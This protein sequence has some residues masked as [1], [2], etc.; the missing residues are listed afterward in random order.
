MAGIL[1]GADSPILGLSGMMQHQEFGPAAG[2]GMGS[3][4]GC[5]TSLS[6][7]AL[8]Y[9]TSVPAPMYRYTPSLDFQQTDGTLNPGRSFREDLFSATPPLVAQSGSDAITPGG[10]FDSSCLQ[11]DAPQPH[12]IVPDSQSSEQDDTDSL[13][14]HFLLQDDTALSKSL[15]MNIRKHKITL[16]DVLRKGLQSL[17]NDSQTTTKPANGSVQGRAFYKPMQGES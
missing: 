5:G 6:A 9:Q 13:L 1:A 16:K 3:L 14:A 4:V 11:Q 12:I 8:S 7:T 15:L 17:E 10:G 2:T